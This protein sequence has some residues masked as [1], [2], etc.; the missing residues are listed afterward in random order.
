MK[1]ALLELN[2][3]QL[4]P[5]DDWY[6]EDPLPIALEEA[7]QATGGFATP[8]IVVHDPTMRYQV[9]DGNRRIHWARAQGVK[10]VHALVYDAEEL[11]LLPQELALLVNQHTLSA[12]EKIYLFLA[13]LDARLGL[14]D[15]IKAGRL[16]A[17]A[18]RHVVKG[19]Q[20]RRGSAIE[21]V[22]Q[23][24][25]RLCALAGSTP[26]S[27]QTYFYR[28]VTPL[29]RETHARILRGELLPKQALQAGGKNTQGD[30]LD[31]LRSLVRGEQ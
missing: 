31:P 28:Y 24:A 16:F 11:S 19:Q 27:L 30:S 3:N 17:E 7:I 5:H 8:I 26:N 10:T 9:V 18:Y 25:S 29:P 22:W 21:E 6:R 1:P 23:T 20:T 14:G 4:V 15:W 2:L 13:A 12:Y